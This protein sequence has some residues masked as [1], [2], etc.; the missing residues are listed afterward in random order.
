VI[1]DVTFAGCAIGAAVLVYSYDLYDREPISV[2][3]L[4]A[5][6]G[7]VGMAASGGLE[8]MAF[9]QL[10][11]DS[12]LALAFVGALCEE[13]A[14]LLVVALLALFAR[15]FND[16]MDGLIY[17][18]MAGLGA[19]LEEGLAVLHATPN[20][21]WPL[22]PDE[23]VR[24][25]GHLVMGGIGGFGMGCLFHRRDRWKLAVA[26]SFLTAVLLHL[27][28]DLAALRADGGRGAAG[29]DTLLAASLMLAGLLLYGRLVVVGS[30]WS[31]EVFAPGTPQRFWR[32]PWSPSR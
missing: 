21:A 15:S 17:G 5:A 23:L 31:M 32:W 30:R 10:E 12:V 2:L 26:A 7:A 24:L 13:T 6:L 1:L 29:R 20:A 3:G 11:L 18:S 19:A 9:R 27:G 14:K 25:C 28:W 22:P 4:A 16:P 8:T